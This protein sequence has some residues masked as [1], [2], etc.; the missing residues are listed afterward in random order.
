MNFRTQEKSHN[1]AIFKKII[2]LYPNS[3][4]IRPRIQDKIKREKH[5][6]FSLLFC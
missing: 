3:I 4:P 1:F 6:A 5:L 2:C